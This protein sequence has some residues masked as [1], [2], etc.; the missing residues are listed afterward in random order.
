MREKL[1]IYLLFNICLILPTTILW[2]QYDASTDNIIELYAQI[3]E[4]KTTSLDDCNIYSKEKYTIIFEYSYLY[5]NK[6][7]NGEYEICETNDGSKTQ[8][9][10][11]P[12]GSNITIFIKEDTPED[13]SV[14]STDLMNQY[15]LAFAIIFT[16]ITIFTLAFLSCCFE[17][18]VKESK[19]FF[20]DK[21]N[22]IVDNTLSS[23]I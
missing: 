18:I 1:L 3:N 22:D 8:L 11:H 23:V 5:L 21:T 19:N 2:W 12:I 14:S 20:I 15:I 6:S 9:K 4:I 13:S 17:T 10:I 16:I 7:Y